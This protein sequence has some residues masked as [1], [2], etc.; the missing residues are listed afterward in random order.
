MNSIPSEK[1]ASIVIAAAVESRRPW[2][3]EQLWLTARRST[4]RFPDSA[5]TSGLSREQA[6]ELVRGRIYEQVLKAGGMID[7][8]PPGQSKPT[9]EQ[10]DAALDAFGIEQWIGL[11]DSLDQV[12]V[13]A[14]LSHIRQ[15]TDE[16][17]QRHGARKVERIEGHAILRDTKLWLAENRGKLVPISDVYWA[18][19][20]REQASQANR[21]GRGHAGNRRSVAELS[22]D[23]S[24]ARRL[25]KRDKQI[26][27]EM[28]VSPYEIKMW[29]ER[30][31]KISYER[32][33]AEAGANDEEERAAA[34]ITWLSM[35]RTKHQRT[36]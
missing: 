20:W 7:A 6:T 10:I 12:S 21:E 27:H 23:R 35:I 2:R 13:Q 33:A 26:D 15:D 17:K 9:P 34:F 4:V 24:L 5:A 19:F 28:T 14:L 1:L 30:A 11:I 16:L 31:A 3:V 36:N 22:S 32:F 18:H 8:L 29:R 25:S